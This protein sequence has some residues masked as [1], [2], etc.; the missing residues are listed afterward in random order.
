MRC[1]RHLQNR[2]HTVLRR[3]CSWDPTREAWKR[4]GLFFELSSMIGSGHYGG[5]APGPVKLISY[6]PEGSSGTCVST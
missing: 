5:E 1:P 2:L 6:H 4:F 3:L